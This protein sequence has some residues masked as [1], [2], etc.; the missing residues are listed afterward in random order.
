MT[1]VAAQRSTA[2]RPCNIQDSDLMHDSSYGTHARDE[3]DLAAVP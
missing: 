1:P 2:E 3:V